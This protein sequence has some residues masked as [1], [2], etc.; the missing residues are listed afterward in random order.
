MNVAGFIIGS[1]ATLST[2]ALAWWSRAHPD[3]RRPWVHDGPVIIL[4]LLGAWLLL[5]LGWPWS[6]GYV[7]LAAACN[8]WFIVRVCPTCL[9]HG[10]GDGPSLHCAVA[11]RLARRG[12]VELFPHRFGEGLRVVAVAWIAPMIGGIVVLFQSRRDPTAV[13]NVV[14]LLAAYALIA[15]LLAPAAA[16]PACERCEN[17]E[18]CP[19]GG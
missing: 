18:A 5:R 2:A 12:N 8:L 9:Y 13:A 6:A 4:Y 10:R 14:F 3:R 15:F 19:R 1:M 17:R 16:K 11:T 7:V